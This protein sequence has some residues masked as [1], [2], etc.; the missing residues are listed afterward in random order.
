VEVRPDDPNPVMFSYFEV[1]AVCRYSET[2]TIDFP[3]KPE[4]DPAW[5]LFDDPFFHSGACYVR[6]FARL[7][8]PV[9]NFFG[10]EFLVEAGRPL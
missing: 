1:L 10:W 8:T 4:R 7:S 6:R 5:S 2:L 3:K 9:T